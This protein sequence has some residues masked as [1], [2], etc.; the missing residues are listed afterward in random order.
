MQKRALS[1]KVLSVSFFRWV[2]KHIKK[3]IKST[4]TSLDWHPN[5]CLLAA[6]TTGFKVSLPTS[7]MYFRAGKCGA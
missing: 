2:S 4:V 3:P 7:E 6:G 5:N 1:G